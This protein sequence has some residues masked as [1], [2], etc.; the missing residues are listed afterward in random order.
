MLHA[1]APL[2]APRLRHAVLAIGD[3]RYAA[4]ITRALADHD[5]PRMIVT[6]RAD[7]YEAIA[8]EPELLLIEDRFDGAPAEHALAAL[9]T[10]NVTTPAFVLAFW[11]RPE[12]VRLQRHLAP[13]RI[14]DEPFD[15]AIIHA[16]VSAGAP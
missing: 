14:V 3:A 6:T 10:A 4:W 13:I 8:T 15:A 5:L 1:I 9:R 12:L 16:I 2:R 7:L 11:R